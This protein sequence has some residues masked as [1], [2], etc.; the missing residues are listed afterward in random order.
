MSE[1]SARYNAGDEDSLEAEDT[2]VYVTAG[3]WCYHEED[4]R[5]I[6]RSSKP[7]VDLPKEKAVKLEY[8]RCPHC[9]P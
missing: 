8:Q 7:K 2:T 9:I 3:A 4:C 5:H 6:T 1:R